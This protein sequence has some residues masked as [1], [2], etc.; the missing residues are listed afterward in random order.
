MEPVPEPVSKPVSEPVSEPVPVINPDPVVK[1][2]KE[3]SQDIAADIKIPE[4]PKSESEE[5]TSWNTLSSFKPWLIILN[6]SII[7]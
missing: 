3:T 2:V 6:Y 7:L 4:V 1:E 5:Q